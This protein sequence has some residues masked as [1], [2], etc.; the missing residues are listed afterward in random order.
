[1]NTIGTIHDPGTMPSNMVRTPVARRTTFI[2]CFEPRR[3]VAIPAR[4]TIA[5]VRILENPSRIFARARSI[6]LSVTKY[7]GIIM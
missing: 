4:M 6:P 2:V 7:K 5:N 3:S 1:M